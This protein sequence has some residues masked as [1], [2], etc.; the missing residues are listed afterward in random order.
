MKKKLSQ[1]TDPAI[2]YAAGREFWVNS[3]VVRMLVTPPSQ[4]K[5]QQYKSLLLVN[6]QQ[7]LLRED[8]KVALLFSYLVLSQNS[9]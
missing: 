5:K 1:F 6:L 9:V 3:S 7:P 4:K 8:S 2:M